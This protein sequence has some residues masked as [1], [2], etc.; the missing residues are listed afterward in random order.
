MIHTKH[1]Q[2]TLC[3]IGNFRTDFSGM[4]EMLMK[5]NTNPKLE[6]LTK[7]VQRQFNDKQNQMQYNND[8]NDH[9]K[10][11]DERHVNEFDTYT[12]DSQE[13]NEHLFSTKG[14]HDKIDHKMLLSNDYNI[15][16]LDAALDKHAAPKD[17]FVFSGIPF[18]PN[19][20]K[21]DGGKIHLPAYTSTSLNLDR[22][23]Y[24][25]KRFSD[26]TNP[27]NTHIHI[28]KINVPEGSKHGAYIAQYSRYNK[29]EH[30]FLMKRNSVIK[31]DRVPE[32]HEIT[33]GDI[34]NKLHVWNAHVIESGIGVDHT[35]DNNY[36]SN[37]AAR[38]NS[39]YDIHKI[40]SNT[41]HDG[42]T[43]HDDE[44][45]S[46]THHDDRGSYNEHINSIHSKLTDLGFINTHASGS[47]NVYEHPTSKSKI[48]VNKSLPNLRL[49]IYSHEK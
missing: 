36:N 31:V 48:I 28:L 21:N 43:T 45:S 40:I 14:D 27:E 25:A 12:G 38:P 42:H 29:G 11:D 26:H 16:H 18:N 6:N 17:F 15:K 23:A 9:Y 5:V 19:E 35:N 7:E 41:G 32:V 39:I 46:T 34:T 44:L 20:V 49:M 37:G 10:F 2:K 13:L 33:N 24:F 3:G 47:M 8:L 1:I 4:Y 30:E 22:A